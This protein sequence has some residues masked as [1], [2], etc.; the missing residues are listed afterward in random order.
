MELVCATGTN[1]IAYIRTNQIAGRE[2]Y[3]ALL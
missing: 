3:V 2:L 1:L